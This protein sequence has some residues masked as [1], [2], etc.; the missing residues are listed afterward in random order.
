MAGIEHLGGL[1]AAAELV[2][3]GGGVMGAATSLAARRAG[4]TPLVLEARPAPASATTAVAT[5]AYRL[6]HDDPDELALAR[7]TVAAFRDFAAATG[8]DRYGSGLVA[9]G[10]IHA[11]CSD[12]GAAAQRE[13]AARQAALGVA[14]VELLGGDAARAR[15][16]FLGPAVRQIRYRAADGV[17]DPKQASLGL[18]EGAA[19]PLLTSCRVTGFDIGGGR[20]TAVRTDRGTV[21]AGACVIAAGPLSGPLARL[22]GVEL[23]LRVLR[24]HKVVLPDVPQVPADAPLVY[25]DDTGAHWRP[26]FRGAVVLAPDADDEEQA[27]AFDPAPDAGFPYAVLDPDRPTSVARVT[28]FWRE[29]WEDGRAPWS[30]HC[31]QYTMTPDHRPLLG[32]TPVEGLYVNTGYSGHGVMLSVAGARVVLAAITNGAASPFRLDRTFV[33]VAKK[34][35]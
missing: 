1:P 31:G 2:I 11:T 15:F 24:R 19:A 22:A 5:G 8:Q 29:V 20:L 14:D 34:P 28:P 27:P 9:N 26:A 33:P 13:V 6:Q 23:P 21:A 35:L 18:L 3:V 4:L 17:L 10:R 25:D 32:A 16:G 7:E 12:E 30:L